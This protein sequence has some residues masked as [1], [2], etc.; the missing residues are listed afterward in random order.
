[1]PLIDGVGLGVGVE[2]MVG[3]GLGV[4]VELMVGIGLGV[5]VELMV[6]VGLGVGGGRSTVFGDCTAKMSKIVPK[7]NET[8]LK[9][10]LEIVAATS[11]P[12][13]LKLPPRS[14]IKI[15]TPPRTSSPIC[16]LTGMIFLKNITFTK[17]LILHYRNNYSNPKSF[18]DF[19]ICGSA[20]PRRGVRFH[21][22]FRIAIY[23]NTNLQ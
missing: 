21:K 11:V 4:G 16:K 3:V 20:P 5:G 12:N 2:L 17:I 19:W 15:R 6:G 7:I 18:V 23:N 10:G 8:N 9:R 13:N 14:P 1:M 22:S